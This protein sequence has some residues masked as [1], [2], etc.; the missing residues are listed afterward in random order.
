[1]SASAGDPAS[2]AGL[3]A[4]LDALR[5][6]L[7]AISASP[8]DLE[9]ILDI[10]VERMSKLCHSDSG[11]IFLPSG[12][13]TFIGVA[14]Y[15]MNPAHVEY[16]RTHPT[17][18]TPGTMVGRVVLSGGP[19][20][21]DDAATDPNYTWTEG[22]ELGA[23]HSFLGVPIRK[24]GRLI[25]A[26]GLARLEI[27]PFTLDEIE[28]VQTFADQAAIIIHNVQLGR[29]LELQREELDPSLPSTVTNLIS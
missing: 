7:R 25:G 2:V 8:L 20:Q 29:T 1:M 19:V 11:M 13:G 15:A 10:A 28:L 3:T 27:R 5:D 26:V 12:E 9:G 22:R 16:E 18:V 17:P 6:V 21:I 23:F 14:G 4:Q 24:E